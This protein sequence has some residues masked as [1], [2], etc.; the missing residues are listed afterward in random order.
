MTAIGLIL[1]LPERSGAATDLN[2]YLNLD[3]DL[4]E[5]SGGS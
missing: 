2:L 1:N 4:P 3:L 5:R